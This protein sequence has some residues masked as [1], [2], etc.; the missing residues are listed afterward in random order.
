MLVTWAKANGAR[1]TAIDPAPQPDLEALEGVE[2]IRATSLDALREIPLPDAMIIDGDHNYFT[3][4]EELRLIAERAAGATLPL[5]LF[6]DV[7]W[8]H[9]RRDDYHDAGAIPAARHP[10]AGDKGGLFPGEAGLRAGGLRY[11]RSAAQEGGS[12]NGVLTAVEDFVADHEQLRLVVIPV[13]FGVGVVWPLDTPWSG[14]LGTLLDPWTATRCS[15]ASRRPVSSTSRRSTS[16]CNARRVRRPCCGGCWSRRRSR[17][18][19]G[20]R[21]CGSAP[22]SRLTSPRSRATRFVAL[23]ASS[24]AAAERV[25]RAQRGGQPPAERVGHRREPSLERRHAGVEQRVVRVGMGARGVALGLGQPGALLP[26]GRPRGA[27]GRRPSHLSAR[28]MWPSTQTSRSSTTLSVL[29]RIT[30]SSA[31][32]TLRPAWCSRSAKSRSK[33]TPVASSRRNAAFVAA[34]GDSTSR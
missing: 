3:V 26:V 33:P 24:V 22:A 21:S 10:V 8:P 28:S 5:L 23:S 15:G 30:R 12:R 17:S 1:V 7:G 29:W 4:R 19:S 31:V 11:P 16:S 32:T 6:H 20:S 2:L 34:H 14:A 25:Q 13:F 18:R 9:G 27:P